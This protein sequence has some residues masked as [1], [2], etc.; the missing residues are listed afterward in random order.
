MCMQLAVHS[1]LL[2]L[3]RSH[4]MQRL[5]PLRQRRARFQHPAHTTAT[6][7]WPSSEKICIF[8]ILTER[9]NLSTRK[10]QQCER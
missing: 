1:L 5:P 6:S 8:I 9:E 4:I 2:L 7:D 3:L 10:P